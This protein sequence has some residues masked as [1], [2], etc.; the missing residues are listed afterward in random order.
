MLKTK[1]KRKKEKQQKLKNLNKVLIAQ[2]KEHCVE[3]VCAVV[4][5]LKYLRKT[6]KIS[7]PPKLFAIKQMLKNLLMRKTQMLNSVSHAINLE[8]LNLYH[9]LLLSSVQ[10]IL[11]HE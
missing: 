5:P 10:S 6:V 1:K 2:L 8:L 3:M 11:W 7:Q 4:L 9:Q